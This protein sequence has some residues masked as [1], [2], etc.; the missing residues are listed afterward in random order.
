MSKEFKYQRIGFNEKNLN[1]V[2]T[3]WANVVEQYNIITVPSKDKDKEK[4]AK[5]VRVYLILDDTEIDL[6]FTFNFFRNQM[7]KKVLNLLQK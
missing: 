5:L 3:E 1:D 2:N 7:L 6:I 4:H